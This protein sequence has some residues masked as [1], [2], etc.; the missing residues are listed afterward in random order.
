MAAIRRQEQEV[1][2]KE[3]ARQEDK[4]KTEDA[5]GLRRQSWDQMQAAMHTSMQQ[6]EQ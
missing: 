1:D 4:R 6:V 5:A 2:L 3:A